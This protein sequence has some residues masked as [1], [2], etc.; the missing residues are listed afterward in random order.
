MFAVAARYSE[1][2]ALPPSGN[3]WEAGLFYMVQARELL[4][5]FNQ[6]DHSLVVLAHGVL[7]TACCR[8]TYSDRI[9]HYSRPSTCQALLL[10]GL[11]EFG[12][13]VHFHSVSIDS[14]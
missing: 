9:Y 14:C 6:G 13:G 7:L 12:L 1:E 11:R 5:T 10:L 3:M 4:S 8:S 2:E